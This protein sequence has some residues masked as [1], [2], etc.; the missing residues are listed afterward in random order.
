MVEPQRVGQ[1]NALYRLVDK[2]QL[3][4]KAVT[5][6]GFIFYLFILIQLEELANLL[7]LS[8]Q[9]CPIQKRREF[10]IVELD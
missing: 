10:V 2:L 1:I 4:I 7:L 8:T 6:A 9:Y 5:F 3:I